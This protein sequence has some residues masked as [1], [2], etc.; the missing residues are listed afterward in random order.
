MM[1]TTRRAI[2]NFKQVHVTTRAAWR[3]W[4][5][6]HHA[7]SPG[8]WLVRFK[9]GYGPAPSYDDIVEEALCV[10]WVD[11]LPRALDAER[12]MLLITPRK[13]K[14]VWSAPNRERVARLIASGLMRPAGLAKVEAAKADGSWDALK[15]AESLE[16][17]PAL[18]KAFRGQQRA[19]A[20]WD[21]FT[22]AS[23]R[24]ILQWLLSAKTDATREKR[25]AEIVAKAAVGKRANFPVDR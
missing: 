19:R 14:S 6:S 15:A 16:L 3:R 13:P 25:V 1:P 11:S 12:T 18:V 2:D 5:S 22:D 7:T 20:N 9:K 23:R 10:G 8:I 17:P 4:L 21:A 24:A